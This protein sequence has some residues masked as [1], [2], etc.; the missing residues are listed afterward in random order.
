M[1]AGQP[2]LQLAVG[3]LLV[4]AVM[5]WPSRGA[6]NTARFLMRTHEQQQKGKGSFLATPHVFISAPGGFVKPWFYFAQRRAVGQGPACSCLDVKLNNWKFCSA[7]PLRKA[8]SSW[9]G[10][11]DD[12]TNFTPHPLCAVG[13]LGC[14]CSWYRLL[15]QG[16]IFLFWFG[17]HWKSLVQRART[18]HGFFHCQLLLPLNML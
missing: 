13:S 17:L 14:S 12:R 16:I 5:M 11:G 3:L 8:G 2:L 15:R 4:P 7:E 6:G 1:P 18:R 10:C 9:W